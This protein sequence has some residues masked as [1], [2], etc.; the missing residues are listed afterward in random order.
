MSKAHACVGVRA[1]QAKRTSE[2][3]VKLAAM[4][5]LRSKVAFYP[6]PRCSQV[7]L[8]Q[9]SLRVATFNVMW[10][11]GAHQ[12]RYH[13]IVEALKVADADVICLQEAYE[14][15]SGSRRSLAALLASALSSGGRCWACLGALELVLVC[16]GVVPCLL[17]APRRVASCRG[18]MRH[19]SIADAA[20][21][22]PNAGLVPLA[23]ACSGSSTTCS[24]R[25]RKSRER[26][27]ASSGSATPFCQSGLSSSLWRHRCRPRPLTN[28]PSPRAQGW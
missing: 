26:T 23:R 19:A 12:E 15:V 6:D 27:A 28:P 17:A 11:Y 10:Q 4:D 14:E 1:R 18:C 25:T 22:R 24:T 7:P 3:A 20:L 9:T 2:L 16:C 8:L 13:A 5:E 21:L